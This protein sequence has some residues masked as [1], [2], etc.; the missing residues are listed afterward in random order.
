MS[1]RLMAVRVLTL[2]GID[3]KI[4]EK[5]AAQNNNGLWR[6]GARLL[7]KNRCGEMR[8]EVLNLGGGDGED[9]ALDFGLEDEEK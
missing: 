1:N 2:A 3:K 4:V 6:M 8:K 9:T 7:G 5:V